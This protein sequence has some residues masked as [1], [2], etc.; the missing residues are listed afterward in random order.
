METLRVRRHASARR[1]CQNNPEKMNNTQAHKK[2]SPA[3]ETSGSRQECQRV[4]RRV[5]LLDTSARDRR[6]AAKFGAP[7]DKQQGKESCRCQ[8]VTGWQSE[9]GLGRPSLTG[10]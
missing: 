10:R 3:R 1:R 5:S 7:T 2:V 8:R 6:D 9:T 4:R